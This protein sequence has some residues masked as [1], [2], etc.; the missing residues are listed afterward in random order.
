[1]TASSVE[2]AQDQAQRWPPCLRQLDGYTFDRI[3][4]SAMSCEVL[5]LLG[6]CDPDEV[7]REHKVK[8]PNEWVREAAKKFAGVHFR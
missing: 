6:A 7:C 4:L 5:R 3:A 1:M 2:L 8:W